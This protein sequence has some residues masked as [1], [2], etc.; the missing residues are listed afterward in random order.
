MWRW[1]ACAGLALA[2]SGASAQQPTFRDPLVDQLVGRWVMDGTIAG[3]RTTHDVSAE[4]VLDHQYLRLQ[5]VSRERRTDGEPAYQ[6]TIYIG[7]DLPTKT[8]GI[9]WLDSFGGIS[10][11]S[12]GSATPAADQL[13]FAFRSERTPVVTHTTFSYRREADAWDLTIDQ[14]EQGKVATFANLRLTRAP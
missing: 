4:W 8:Y 6:A 3:A 7:W 2:A 13:A 1:F 11:Q 5:E 9:V 12:L 14:A 10:V